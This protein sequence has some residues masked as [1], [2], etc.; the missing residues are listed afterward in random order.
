MWSPADVRALPTK[1][2]VIAANEAIK[3]LEIRLLDAQRV[4]DDLQREM[5]KRR[6]WLAP[7]RIVP[8]EIMSMVLAS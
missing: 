7:I 8:N 6:A 1:N 2:D 3:Q 4:V 5:D